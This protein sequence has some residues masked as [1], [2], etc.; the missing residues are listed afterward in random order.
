M[1]IAQKIQRI[2]ECRKNDIAPKFNALWESAKIQIEFAHNLQTLLDDEKWHILLNKYPEFMRDWQSISNSVEEYINNVFTNV[3]VKNGDSYIP[4]GYYEAIYHKIQ[5]DTVEICITGPVSTGKSVFLRALT[6]APEYVIPSGN[7]KTTAARTVF[8]N[9]TIKSAEVLFYS[10]KEFANILNEYVCQLNKVIEGGEKLGEWDIN[11][12]SISEFCKRIKSS[13][14]YNPHCFGKKSIPGVDTGVFADLYFET[15]QMYIDNVDQYKS[16]LDH[17]NVPL[18]EEQI[19]NGELIKFVSYRKS[20]IDDSF[21]C[22]ALAVQQ[23]NV[24]WPLV[25]RHKEDL[26]AITLVDTMGIGE[27]KF[28]V[29][30]D[31]LKIVKEHADLAICLCRIHSNTQNPESKENSS[32]IKVISNIR[33][34]KLEEWVYYL[35][36]KEDSVDISDDSVE[37]LRKRI[38]K[39]MQ[40]NAEYFQLNPDYWTSIHFVKEK[41]PNANE[42][43]NFFVNTVLGSLEKTITAIDK[44]FVDK[45]EGIHEKNIQSRDAILE[46]L[47]KCISTVPY[48]SEIQQRKIKDIDNEVDTILIEINQVLKQVRAKLFDKDEQLRKNIIGSIKPILKDPEIFNIYGVEGLDFNIIAAF[49]KNFATVIS[50][51]NYEVRKRDGFNISWKDIE[52]DVITNVSKRVKDQNAPNLIKEIKEK[53]EFFSRY[54]SC[55]CRAIFARLNDIKSNWNIDD[56]KKSCNFSGREL[57]FFIDKREELYKAIWEKMSSSSEKVGVSEKDVTTVKDELCKAVMEVL[58]SHSIIAVSSD[59]SSLMAFV[60]FVKL[61]DSKDLSQEVRE[62]VELTINLPNIVDDQ[63]GK[64]LRLNLL[65]VNLNYSDEITAA[66]ST[67]ECLFNL[68]MNLRKGL[69]VKYEKTFEAYNVFVN[70]V[71]PLYDRVFCVNQ[72]EEGKLNSDAYK[73][74]KAYIRNKVTQNYEKKDYVKCAEAAKNFREICK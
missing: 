28:C 71:T 38:W 72:N 56:P 15:F 54:L 1:S 31:L 41:Q 37:T 16:W 30:S 61:V 24:H 55:A 34:R 49:S 14:A 57:E 63:T 73:D 35:C 48:S 53:S 68:D 21:S 66:K 22:I 36:N 51:I 46:S 64:D 40:D 6:G 67:W 25:T 5:K 4:K 12:E 45:L 43:V 9:S 42:I 29:E 19:Q 69:L 17:K 2:V 32:F 11:K 20:L 58:S 50:A 33:D 74:F 7:S 23:A 44:F 10:S 59:K 60:D 13:K 39:E 8:S 3:G 18:T 70:L 62:F 52:Q 27:A 47:R 26:G 65:S